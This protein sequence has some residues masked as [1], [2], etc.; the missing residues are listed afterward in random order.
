MNQ[1]GNILCSVNLLNAFQ[2]VKENQ[3]M[4]G[5]DGV[6]IARFEE[7]LDGNLAFLGEEIR[8]GIYS[9]LP[10]LKILVAKP[11]GE[12]RGLCIPAVRDRVAQAAVL[13]VIGPVLEK[14]FEDCSFAYR[15]GRS[16]KQ[17]VHRI[18]E[19]FDEG[20]RWVVDADVDAFF[21]SVDHKLLLAKVERFI[22]DEGIV[23]LIKFWIKGEI[24]DGQSIKEMDKGIPQGS[25]I[26]PVLANLFLDEF[27]EALLK[28]GYK[29]VRYAD[30]FVVLCKSPGKAREALE[31]STNALEKLL[32]KLDESDIVSFDEGFKYLGVIFVRS[33]VM[34]PF[35]RQKKE[36]K[37][38]Y[39][40]PPLN[41]EEYL[42]QRNASSHIP[43]P[44]SRP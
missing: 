38:L 17:A 10:L 29:A 25:P 7:E 8:R 16:V 4:A 37:V 19:Y 9:P 15:K 22:P 39:F 12:P 27:D 26:S 44:D 34:V 11:N 36:K 28:G 5:V 43:K 32:L 20:Y 40:P 35:E 24:W 41:M 3:G 21:D 13:N 18:K 2:C 6:T 23:R 33:M 31:F 1:L 30:D 14:E 42:A